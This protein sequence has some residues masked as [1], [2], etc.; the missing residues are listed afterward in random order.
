MLDPS[1]EY[2][3]YIDGYTPGGIPP[4]QC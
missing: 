1:G 3:V 4:P 2:Y